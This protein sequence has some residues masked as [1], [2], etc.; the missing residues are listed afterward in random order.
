MTEEE[1]IAILEIVDEYTPKDKDG[2]YLVSLLP[3]EYAWEIYENKNEEL[4]EFI[5]K[6]KIK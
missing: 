5:G 2:D 1:E 6:L 3:F 4:D